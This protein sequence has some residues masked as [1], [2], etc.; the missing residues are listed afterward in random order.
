[1][2]IKPKDAT[3]AVIR[4]GRNRRIA[5]C[6]V[7]LCTSNCS[8][9]SLIKLS[10]T[11]PFNTA[12]PDSAMNPTPADIDSGISRSQSATKPPDNANGTP[13]KTNK[14]SL[15]L[16]NTAINK[17]KMVINASGITICIRAAAEAKFSNCPPYSNQYPAGKGCCLRVACNSWTNEP[18][19][20]PSTLAVTMTR[21][22]PFS[23]PT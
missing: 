11:R 2:G 23:R 9:S 12:T 5:P 10:I 17:T 18:K 7:A 20:R 21:R 22:L 1:M 3:K 13:L 8:R 15:K 6:H 19:S 4:T 16:W 14:L